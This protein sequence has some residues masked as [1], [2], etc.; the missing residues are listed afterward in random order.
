MTNLRPAENTI[1]LAVDSLI[2]LHGEAAWIHY[3][4]GV[5]HAASLWTTTDGND[6]DFVNFVRQISRVIQERDLLLA[7]LSTYLESLGVI[8]TR[9][10]W[11]FAKTSIS[12][13]GVA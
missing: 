11:I 2:R 3:S 7:K 12:T 9:S 8:S 5:K 4:K 6:R 10:P 1:H 13:M